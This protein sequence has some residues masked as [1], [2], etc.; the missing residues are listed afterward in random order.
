MKNATSA[1]IEGA[2]NFLKRVNRKLNEIYYA[3]PN[4]RDKILPY[5]DVLNK[6]IRKKRIEES[7]KKIKSYENK[8]FEEKLALRE[9]NK[10]KDLSTKELK[11]FFELFAGPTNIDDRAVV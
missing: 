3:F 4:L 11:A 6:K 5:R 10:A 1:N 7:L 9:K 8:R 2:K